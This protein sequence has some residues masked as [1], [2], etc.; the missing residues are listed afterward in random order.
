VTSGIAYQ[1]P[2]KHEEHMSQCNIR[3]VGGCMIPSAVQ[4]SQQRL[5]YN[6]QYMG[7]ILQ[8]PTQKRRVQVCRGEQRCVPCSS[9]PLCIDL[10]ASRVTRAGMSSHCLWSPVVSQEAGSCQG[11]AQVFW[12]AILHS[13]VEAGMHSHLREAGFTWL[14]WIQ[15]V[16]SATLTVVG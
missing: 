11:K 12:R 16:I 3:P 13:E 8:G 4:R 9:F 6:I 7:E 14:W 1:Q 2:Y 15:G 10:S 5:S